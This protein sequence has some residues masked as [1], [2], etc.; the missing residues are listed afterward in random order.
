MVGIE[1]SEYERKYGFIRKDGTYFVPPQF[2][3]VSEYWSAGDWGY[4]IVYNVINDKKL[5]GLLDS[6][7]KLII[8]T[9]YSFISVSKYD[10]EKGYIDVRSDSLER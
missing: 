4:N 5:Y 9:K 2:D 1:E 3:G 8:D 7:G 6:N 10:V